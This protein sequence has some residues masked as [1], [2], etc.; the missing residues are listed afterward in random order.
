M[1]RQRCRAAIVAD[2]HAQQVEAEITLG[3]LRAVEQNDQLT[4]RS[5]AHELGVALGL[6]NTYFKRCIKKGLIKVRQVPANRYAYYLT[7]KGFS[8]KSRLTAEFLS[9]SLNLFRQA[10]NDYR[11]ILETCV[12]QSWRRIALCGVSDLAEI[13]VLYA[14]DYPVDIVGIVDPR[15]A[16]PTVAG[17]P[18]VA[19][20][21]ELGPIDAFV[22]TALYEA[23]ATYADLVRRYEPHRILAPKLLEI[24]PVGRNGGERRP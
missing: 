20:D 12:E 7:P 23:Q 15:A 6:V 5:A 24:T 14:R 18:V 8:E 19:A 10:Q 1:N 21:R 3:L 22:I 11:S 2:N 17:L 9:Q 13:F 4:Q 16:T